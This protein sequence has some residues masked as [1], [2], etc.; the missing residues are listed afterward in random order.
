MNRLWVR[1]SLVIFGVSLLIVASTFALESTGRLWGNDEQPTL[2]EEFNEI[3]ETLPAE[4][5]QRL[6]EQGRRNAT[7]GITTLIITASIVGVIVGSWLSR[8]LTSPLVALETAAKAIKSYDYKKRVPVKGS[9]EVV[10]LA[11]SFNEMAERLD[12]SETLRRNLLSDVAHELRHPLHILQGNLTAIL[13]GIYPM[14]EEEIGRL[15]TQTQHL[16]TLV[17]DLHELAQAEANQLVL[18]KQETDMGI[19]V[20]ETAVSFKPAADAKKVAVSVELLGA[21][22]TLHVDTNRLRQVLTNLFT[23]SLHYTQS[24][25]KIT[26]SVEEQQKRLEVRIHDTGAGITAENLPHIF[27]RF[28]RADNARNRSEGTG[29]GLAIVKA[30]VEAHEGWITAESPGPNQGSTFIITLPT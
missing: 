1:I 2:E 12:Q 17:N 3:V 23:N 15:L 16:T 21:L 22:P 26:V 20:K 19:L 4:T 9:Q 8:S 11:I 28:Y 24:G 18:H 30:I 29:L 10:A 25:G 6:R 7:Q 13:D 14:D 5:I 27:D